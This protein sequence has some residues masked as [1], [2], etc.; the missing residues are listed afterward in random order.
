M[1]V[2]LPTVTDGHPMLAVLQ[3]LCDDRSG[4][5]ILHPALAVGDN[6]GK[7]EC[8]DC[9]LETM[10]GNAACCV[11]ARCQPYCLP[12]CHVCNVF[13]QQ[14]CENGSSAVSLVT[15]FSDAG[16]ERA[17]VGGGCPAPLSSTCACCRL[18]I[19]GKQPVPALPHSTACRL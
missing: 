11:S 7:V 2:L 9:V 10:Q 14:V 6:H 12:A 4:V 1:Q 3:N 5:D 8:E 16:Y 13:E 18:A 19:P 17:R 15:A